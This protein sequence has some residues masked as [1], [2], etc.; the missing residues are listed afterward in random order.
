MNWTGTYAITTP[1]TTLT[2]AT[3]TT[4]TNTGAAW[5]TTAPTLAG[6]YIRLLTGTGSPATVAIV[7]N[8]ATQITVASWPNGTP[9]SGTTYE[10]VAIMN[11]G[12]AVTGSVNFNTNMIVEVASSAAI[13]VN[14]SFLI[15]FENS[16]TVRWGMSATTMPTFSANNRTSVG[17]AGS[18]TGFQLASTLTITPN[19]SYIKI[20]DATT[21]LAP[22]PS[23]VLGTASTVHHIWVE[24][25]L[26]SI[27][28]LSGFASPSGGMT[29]SNVFCR[30]S[31][32]VLEFSTTT[33]TANQI[34]D[35]CWIE[36]NYPAS[37]VVPF[38]YA[39]GGSNLQWVR[40]SVFKSIPLGEEVN[41]N[42]GVEFRLSESYTYASSEYAF[43]MANATN[44]DAGKHNAFMMSVRGSRFFLGAGSGGAGTMTS[45]SNDLMAYGN[46]NQSEAISLASTSYA[47]ATSNFDYMAGNNSAAFENVD[48]TTATTSTATPNQYQNLTTARTNAQSSP[49]FPLVI[50]NIS[51]G[52]PTN[53]SNTI[54]FDCENG[55]T[56]GQG[57]TVNGTSSGATLPV[58]ATTGFVVGATVEIGYGTARSEVQRISSISAGTSLTFEQNLTFTHT[59]AEAD[60]VNLALR[61]YGLPFIRY[62]TASQ[63]YTMQTQIPDQSVWGQLWTGVQ[64]TFNGETFTWKR[65]GHS[66]TLNNL[67]PGITYYFTPYAYNAF[68]ELLAGTET[69]FSTPGVTTASTFS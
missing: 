67:Q 11:N 1:G 57:S 27:I 60:T 62:G 15:N 26:T 32:G 54:T 59:A 68:G 21:A 8:T 9:A 38:L 31:S 55:A 40:N 51:T 66:I 5:P 42:S 6:L 69:T 44:A 65:T 43:V 22:Q 48:T 2:S 7:S 12:D 46:Q 28:Q 61:Y 4:A 23:T 10:L 45:F 37:G 13:T 17:K 64:T 34:F 36:S 58:A 53:Y 3:A 41:T 14:G 50:N 33:S 18:W 24:D 20:Q 29:I 35:T 47:T 56:S 63:T 52:S 19:F 16:C 49:N 25:C 30:N 39:A